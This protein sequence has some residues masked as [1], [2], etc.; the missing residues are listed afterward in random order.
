MEN[1]KPRFEVAEINRADGELTLVINGE[2]AWAVGKAL[3]DWRQ[4]HEDERGRP[5]LKVNPAIASLGQFVRDAGLIL[6][7]NL[8]VEKF[9]LIDRLG[10]VTDESA[11]D[12]EIAPPVE[13]TAD[14][15]VTV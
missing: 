12:S 5:Y 1:K 11:Y 15:A 13:D 2:F 7:Q 10:V 14:I 6:A 3:L 4:R 9:P 8:P